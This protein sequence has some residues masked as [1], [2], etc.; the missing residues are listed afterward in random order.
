VYKDGLVSV[1]DASLAR[2]FMSFGFVVVP[3]G[4]SLVACRVGKHLQMLVDEFIEDLEWSKA[5]S[6]SQALGV[7]IH[8]EAW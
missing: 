6:W 5:F 8:R 2:D 4:T 1:L 3:C 7:L